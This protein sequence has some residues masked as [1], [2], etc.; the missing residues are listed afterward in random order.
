MPFDVS[1]LK[2]T[3]L[4]AGFLCLVKFQHGVFDRLEC[5]VKIQPSNIVVNG[6]EQ[7]HTLFEIFVPSTLCCYASRIKNFLLFSKQAL[8]LRSCKNE[9]SWLLCSVS[10]IVMFLQK[11]LKKA[12]AA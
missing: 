11:R 8:A 2:F 9:L 5:I 7:S 1:Q 10:H 4:E 12:N 6:F 3:F